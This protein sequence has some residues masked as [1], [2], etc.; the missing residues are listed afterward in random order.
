MQP[1]GGGRPAPHQRPPA[2]RAA[3]TGIRPGG[4]TNISAAIRSAAALLAAEGRPNALP[5]LVLLTDGA[6]S[7]PMVPEANVAALVAAERAR[8][9]RAHVFTIGLGRFVDSLL[10]EAIA[11]SPADFFY[12]PRPADL[13]AIYDRIGA[14]IRALS[15]TDLIIT[16]DLDPSF[17]AYVPGSGQPAPLRV[18]DSLVWTRPALPAAGLT[19]SY[20]LQARRPGRQRVGNLRVRYL[21]ADGTRRTYRPSEPQL[22]VAAVYG[23]PLPGATPP[24]G[25]T[26]TSPATQ[27]PGTPSPG[28]TAPPVAPGPTP[29]CEGS[30]RWSVA[31]DVFRDAVG[32]GGYDCPGCNGT[33]DGGDAAQPLTGSAVVAVEDSLERTLW[34]GPVAVDP[35]GR[36]SALVSVC[37]PPPYRVILVQAPPGTVSCPNSPSDRLADGPTVSG[38]YTA[39]FALWGGCGLPTVPPP[40]STAPLVPITCPNPGVAP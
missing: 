11:S 10:L 17:V 33:W 15:L 40:T 37:A 18:A 29:M 25:P 27:G 8:S 34:Q 14:E 35:S 24:P 32:T 38:L 39:R 20:T 6:P 7:R 19:I 23:T 2:L 1:D 3:L 5:V 36:A 21:D 31:I 28:P 12:A 16:D 26:P 13:A 22:E 30:R 4:D 9:R